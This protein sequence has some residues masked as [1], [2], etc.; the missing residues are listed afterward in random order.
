MVFVAVGVLAAGWTVIEHIW[1]SLLVCIEENI[2][3]RIELIYRSTN[4][5]SGF[6]RTRIPQI[7]V[8]TFLRKLCQN[9][10]GLCRYGI[11]QGINSLIY[12]TAV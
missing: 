11:K 5:L 9:L 8:F 3:S 6:L 4:L 7:L 2:V 12:T 10:C 1:L